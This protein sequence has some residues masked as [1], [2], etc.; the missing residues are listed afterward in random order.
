MCVYRG[1]YN[2]CT[3]CCKVSF[4]PALITKTLSLLSHTH[5]HTC[6]QVLMTEIEKEKQY[7]P[8]A[9]SK[10]LHISTPHLCTYVHTVLSPYVRTYLAV[11]EWKWNSEGL[12]YLSTYVGSSTVYVPR[13]CNWLFPVWL[14]SPLFILLLLLLLLLESLVTS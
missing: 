13:C 1:I 12:M 11:N 6:L 9:R 5:T 2:V 8:L 14:L 10:C 7:S 3:R 4:L